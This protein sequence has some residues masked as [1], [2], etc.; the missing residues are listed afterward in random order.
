MN[1]GSGSVRNMT[2]VI[3]DSAYPRFLQVAYQRSPRL[4]SAPYQEQLDQLLG[5]SFGSS[6]YYAQHLRAQGIAAEDVIVNAVPAQRRWL[7]DHG[8]RFMA[9][10]AATREWL[11]LALEAQVREASPDVLLLL[12]MGYFSDLF[13]RRLRRHVGMLVGQVAC[14]FDFTRDLGPY[15]LVLSSLPHFVRR[16]RDRGVR[17]ELLPLAF[18]PSVRQ[19][20]PAT[21]R[22]VD[23]SFVGS[24]GAAHGAGSQLLDVV[25][26]AVPLQLWT[27][28]A[29]VLAMPPRLQRRRVGEAWGLDMYRVL[30]RSKVTV[31][32][33]IDIA[34]DFANNLRLFEA[35]GMGAC[36]LTDDK[37]NLRDLFDPGVE[38]VTYSDADDCVAKAK[39][40]IEDDD[41]RNQIA[42][43]GQ[44]RTLSEHTYAD[45]VRTLITLV[46]GVQ[47]ASPPPP[48]VH[49]ADALELVPRRVVRLAR[50]IERR[51]RAM[52]IDRH[53]S[54]HYQRLSA[55]ELDD[56]LISAWKSPSIAP[57][58]RALVDRQLKDM[59][60]GQPTPEFTVAAT[61]IDATRLDRL[62]LLEVGCASGYYQDVL[63]HLAA[64]SIDYTGCDYS[65]SLLRQ[66]RDRSP[67]AR[68]VLGDAARLPVHDATF[69]VVLSAAV[70]MHVPAWREALREAARTS[71]SWLVLHRT[72]VSR[73]ADTVLLSK[74]AYGVSVV[75]LVLAYDE[76]QKAIV[77]VG[78]HVVQEWS[79]GS[80]QLPD[81]G[82][83]VE[84]VT[85]LI[86]LRDA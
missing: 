27:A 51:T 85:L 25:A 35:T 63:R 9:R 76:L 22:D 74:D 54:E 10:G 66:G 72:P 4:K 28:E 75:E 79:L 49:L 15:D 73:E 5:A 50:K 62:S 67:Y 37:R 86:R 13:L 46:G 6:G 70:L 55:V 1:W 43:A 3:A 68:L 17:S 16:F 81:V 24:V 32:R 40:L 29:N 26:R 36:L 41:A 19:S 44:K 57:L 33:H 34:G 31:N 2:W 56:T 7:A 69:D 58:Q 80:S 65:E 30:G 61:A 45:R 23:L 53:V 11:A 47:P 12:D 78:G 82:L 77:E 84:V 64:A 48:T 39:W 8:H 52:M 18:E 38:V 59:R 14:P 42:A 20:L 21:E 71:R 83:E 60:A